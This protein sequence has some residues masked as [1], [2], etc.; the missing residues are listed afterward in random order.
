MLSFFLL[1]L[2]VNPAS[3]EALRIEGAT[4]YVD[5]AAPRRRVTILVRGGRIA[6]V[7]A[8]SRARQLGEHARVLDLK[9]AILFPGWSDAHGHLEGLGKAL[10]EADLKGT[11]SA[12]E[13]ARRLATAAA[14]LSAQSWV[15]GRGWDQ[16]RWPGSAFPDAR[17]LDAVLGDRPVAARRIDGHALWVS[18]AALAAAQVTAQTPDPPGGRIIR[19][20]DGS[21]S[22]VLVDRAMDFVI[23][24]MPAAS[25][26]DFE[27]RILA[28]TRACARVG[29]TQVQ[30]ASAYRRS[31]VAALARLADSGRLPIRIYATVSSEE[32]ELAKFLAEPPRIGQGRDFLTVRAIKAYADGA[33]GSRGA[34]LFSDYADDPGNRGLLTSSPQRL[35]EL[36]TKARRVGWQLWIHAIGDHGN[37][38]ALDAFAAAAA[39]VPDAP[40]GGQRP[41][42]E[43]AQVLAVEDIPRFAR[44]RVIASM[45]PTHATSDMPWAERRLGRG[46]LVGAYAWRSLTKSGARI[47]G[48]SDFPVESE[49]PLLGF[50]AAVTRQGLS[51]QPSGGWMPKERLSRSEAL[52]L[53]TSEAARA[54]F[55]E[56]GRGRIAVGYDA[57]LTAFDRDPL[58]VPAREIPRL[59]AV[60]TVVGGR[61]V[62]SAAEEAAQ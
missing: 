6:F 28:A 57:D 18:S 52:S 16:N 50:Y 45:Q 60:L 12:G 37:R 21:P 27:R 4:V 1:W 47:A 22:G 36:A 38:A 59:R 42:V 61:V 2:T 46:R 55:E 11:D 23:R 13:A 32:S 31:S 19:R 25:E 51:G 48:G 9:G 56:R 33:L 58:T 8:P 41:R 15:E 53:F 14:S 24:R 54:A 20:P 34:A 17:D 29:L 30:D 62:Y 40:T 39:A 10:E 26:T 7:G 3:E 5:A 49:N 43:H 44:E 35:A